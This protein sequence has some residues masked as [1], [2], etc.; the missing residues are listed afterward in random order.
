M[1]YQTCARNILTPYSNKTFIN[2]WG[3]YISQFTDKMPPSPFRIK[4]TF[5]LCSFV[6][7]FGDTRFGDDSICY[8]TLQEPTAGR[9]R[10][11]PQLRPQTSIIPNAKPPRSL[12]SMANRSL[13]SKANRGC[14]E[15]REH[16]PERKI[17]D[18]C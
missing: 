17:G 11:R 7:T 5:C 6:H 1:G 10:P 14:M 12:P 8:P 2:T 18:Y 13:P 4:L 16:L 15:D 3:K 9:T